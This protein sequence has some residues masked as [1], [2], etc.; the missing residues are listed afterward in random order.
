MVRRPYRK[1]GEPEMEE[2]KAL[3]FQH[4]ELSVSCLTALGASP[5]LEVLP[6]QFQ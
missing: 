3:R 2:E 6:E 5:Y 4:S 1:R